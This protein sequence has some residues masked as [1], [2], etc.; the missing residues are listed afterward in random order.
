MYY[1]KEI[2]GKLKVYSLFIFEKLEGQVLS[3]TEFMFSN[4][5][6]GPTFLS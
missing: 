4:F 6:S 5:I 1:M 2:I 3:Q